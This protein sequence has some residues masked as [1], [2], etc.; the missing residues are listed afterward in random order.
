M[1]L[2]ESHEEDVK[3]TK[4]I[5]RAAGL[6]F[7]ANVLSLFPFG[8]AGDT[9]HGTGHKWEIKR[10]DEKSFRPS[11]LYVQQSVF[12]PDVLSYLAEKSY[13]KSLYMI[14]GV[15]IG[16][17]AKITHT[18]TREVGG[19]FNA[20][21]PLTPAGVPADLAG[22]LYGS[23]HEDIYERKSIPGSFVFAYR[24]REIRYIKKINIVKDIDYT[25]KADLHN[26]HAKVIHRSITREPTYIGTADEIEVKGISGADFEEDRDDTTIV[27]GCVIVDSL[28]N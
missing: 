9:N 16:R 18:K 12:Q 23:K 26:L 14:V 11:R 20:T 25:K 15:R 4:E 5:S 17:D 28:L 13:R 6:G 27:D 10:V 2:E 7:S 22:K 3:V 21:V 8:I 1:K 19:N 24:L